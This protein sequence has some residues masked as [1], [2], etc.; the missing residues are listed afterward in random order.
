MGDARVPHMVAT[1]KIQPVAT[2]FLLCGENTEA[3]PVQLKGFARHLFTTN[4]EQSARIVAVACSARQCGYFPLAGANE[5]EYLILA[6]TER[7]LEALVEYL[8]SQRVREPRNPNAPRQRCEQVPLVRAVEF[9]LSGAVVRPV[10]V[11]AGGPTGKRY[12]ALYPRQEATKQEHTVQLLPGDTGESVAS[13]TSLHTAITG[14]AFV[15]GPKRGVGAEGTE[16]K[17]PNRTLAPEEPG[18]AELR[19]RKRRRATGE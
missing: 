4:T 14:R 18:A 15:A 9:V 6:P 16:H 19:K 8:R 13:G 5:G 1:G 11:G 10:A 17:E 12:H 3:E 2:T 7:V